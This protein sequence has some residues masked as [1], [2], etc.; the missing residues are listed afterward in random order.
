LGIDKNTLKIGEK[1]GLAGIKLAQYSS[2]KH[3]FSSEW[4]FGV[5]WGL[6]LLIPTKTLVPNKA[7]EEIFIGGNMDPHL[8]CSFTSKDSIRMGEIES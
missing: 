5:W 6:S 4:G 3:I 7:L 1:W 2:T 8:L